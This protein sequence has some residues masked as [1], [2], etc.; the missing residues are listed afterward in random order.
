M[1]TRDSHDGHRVYLTI[2]IQHGAVFLV[3]ERA[4]AP[5]NTHQAP[6]RTQGVEI[7]EPSLDGDG[8]SNNAT[9]SRAIG[10]SRGQLGSYLDD[11]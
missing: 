1:S 4:W 7:V 9:L 6:P 10:A 5:S 3:T 8:G 2:T 11:G